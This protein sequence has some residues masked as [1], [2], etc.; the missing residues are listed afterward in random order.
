MKTLKPFALKEGDTIGV[1]APAYPF[2]SNNE[3]EYYESYN[4]GRS[5]LEKMGFKIKESKNLKAVEWWRAGT[6]QQRAEDINVMYRDPEVKAIIAHDGGN[7]CISLL[8]Y[9]DYDLIANNPKPFIGFSNITNIHSA[10]YTKVGLVGFHMG[11][12]TY[13]LGNYWQVADEQVKEKGFNYFHKV[14]SDTEQLGTIEPLTKWETWREGNAQGKLFGGNLSML[15]SLV[16]TPYFP[17]IEDLRSSIFF[18][19]LDNSPSYRI[20]RA[21]THLKYIGLFDVISGMLIGKLVDMKDTA[22]GGLIEP[23]HKE[24]VLSVLSDYS[25]PIL[26]NMDFG[27]KMVQIPMIVGLNVSMNAND[28]SF[29]YLESAVL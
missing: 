15:D 19:E 29:K 10:I 18:W 23:T 17:D 5:E 9:L 1:V 4:K 27:H 12:L 2:P 8:E 24:I 28:K 7:D 20:E 13:E 22:Q 21:L 6:P 14:I 3:P 26:A 25:F 16:G 11:L